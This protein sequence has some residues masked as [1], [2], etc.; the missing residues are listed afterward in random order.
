LARTAK[1]CAQCR[2]VRKQ[3]RIADPKPAKATTESSQD[4]AIPDRDAH[5]AKSHPGMTTAELCRAAG[6]GL[7]TVQ[8]WLESGFLE[9]KNVGIPGGGCRRV[10]AP[11]Q[12]ERARVLKALHRKGV[13]LGRL[14]AAD[15]SFDAGQAYVVY[16]GY[17]LRACPD[18]TAAIAAVVRAR[19]PCS[20]VD[21]SAIR[22]GFDAA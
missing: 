10:F 17:E 15:L 7:S 3:S 1:W 9:A 14:V 13:S 22:M 4:N 11:G 2:L 12:L 21:L 16:D 6:L 5:A 18:A 19:R 8:M 20:A